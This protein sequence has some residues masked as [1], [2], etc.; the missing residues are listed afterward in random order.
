VSEGVS[1]VFRA[2]HKH[3]FYDTHF[4]TLHS[5]VHLIARG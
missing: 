1:S 4:S 2:A 3:H 5:T